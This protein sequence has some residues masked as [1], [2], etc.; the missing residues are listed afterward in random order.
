[1]TLRLAGAGIEPKAQ[2]AMSKAV[3]QTWVDEIIAAI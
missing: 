2:V 3:E 1:M